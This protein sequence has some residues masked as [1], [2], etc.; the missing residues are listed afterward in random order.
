MYSAKALEFPT[1][2]DVRPSL[3]S[4][5]LPFLDIHFSFSFLISSWAF[6]HIE[7]RI[8]KETV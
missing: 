4:I 8:T 1:V 3:P 7:N 2:Y 5:L 6:H